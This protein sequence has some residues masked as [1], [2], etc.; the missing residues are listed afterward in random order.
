MSGSG[1]LGKQTEG[2]EPHKPIGLL[3]AGEAKGFTGF[4]G[5]SEV[6]KG[7]GTGGSLGAGLGGKL[8]GGGLGSGLGGG[9]G[10]GI[11][12]GLGG[13]LGGGFGSGLFAAG[14]GSGQGT[15]GGG[16]GG[17]GG[18]LF[19]GTSLFGARP[20]GSGL[21]QNAD[22]LKSTFLASA[23]KR[24]DEG[25]EEGDENT[26]K[27]DEETVVKVNYKSPYEKI[28]TVSTHI[29]ERESTDHPLLL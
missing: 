12:G 20:G 11:G 5:L 27:D 2:G 25:E 10:G 22:A 26:G 23:S 6:G 9:L 21:L 13:G 28:Y 8:S 7:T 15:F 16:L 4:A 24:E 19:G 17:G 3:G 14:S 1:L 29:R 18:N